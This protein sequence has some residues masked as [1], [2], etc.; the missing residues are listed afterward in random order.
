MNSIKRIIGTNIKWLRTE[1]TLSSKDLAEAVGVSPTA[2]SDWETGKSQ[3]KPEKLK[4][5]AEYFKVS[6]AEFMKESS[7]RVKHALYL[8]AT[9]AIA[10]FNSDGVIAVDGKALSADDKKRAIALLRAAFGKV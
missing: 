4:K 5:L 7:A 9:D 2:V 1:A 10:F 3:P 6:P 8:D